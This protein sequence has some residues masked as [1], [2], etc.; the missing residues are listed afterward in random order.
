MY[1]GF[2]RLTAPP[3]R[4]SPDSRF[5]YGSKSHNKALS[6]LRYGL[7]QG[8]GFIV[9]TGAIGVGKTT[10]VSQLFS[11]LD[12]S[13]VI[14]AQIVT[15]NVQADD[16]LRLIV[17]AFRIAP[18][19]GDKASLLRNLEGFLVEQY[20]AGRR[21]L[22]VVDEAQ[23][24]PVQTIEELRMLSN[25]DVQGQP[26]FQS[27]LLGQP[28]FNTMLADPALEQLRQRVIASYSLEPMSAVDTRHY[29]EH[30]LKM[31]D[32]AG[33]PRFADGAFAA[34][35]EAAG[36]IPRRINTLC[37]RL[38]IY[39][40]LEEL[41]V[42]DETAVA[43]VVADLRAE[44]AETSNGTGGPAAAR[45]P[46]PEARPVPVAAPPA[47]GGDVPDRME[48]LERSVD[49]HEQVLRQL[50]QATA[51][52]LSLWASPPRQAMRQQEDTVDAPGE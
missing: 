6:Y 17:S 27:F 46:A 22:L 51:D 4:L 25:F 34:I 52:L 3:F 39:G 35:H 32:W 33:D 20:R 9:I 5:F 38:L 50:M 44:L 15:T 14:A 31:A 36:G 48:R 23:N 2:Y 11:E 7:H 13:K 28:Q 8:E 29:I 1:E 40:A 16:A 45:H 26:L 49:V 42:F 24:L 41:H 18:G 10:L 43:A 19:S 12:R 37:S 30:R 21:V 47:L